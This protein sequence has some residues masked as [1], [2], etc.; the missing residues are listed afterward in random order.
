MKR[1]SKPMELSEKIEK[2]KSSQPRAGLDRII[3]FP[4][5]DVAPGYI[6]LVPWERPDLLPSA[7]FQTTLQPFV[8]KNVMFRSH[9]FGTKTA[10]LF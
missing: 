2:P 4:V 5:I 6:E 10:G 8:S 7:R 3:E 9:L 1:F